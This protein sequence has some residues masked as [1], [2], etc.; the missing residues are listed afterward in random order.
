LAKPTIGVTPFGGRPTK[1]QAM[2]DQL[3]GFFTRIR[4]EYRSMSDLEKLLFNEVRHSREQQKL[5][6][7]GNTV[8]KEER[9]ING[10]LLAQ[11]ILAAGV[12]Q[13]K[14]LQ[15]K[16][17]RIVGDLDLRNSDVRIIVRLAKC[18]I[19][20]G[21]DISNSTT[22]TVDLA[23]SHL[24]C[25]R[26]TAATIVGGLR[27]A[28]GFLAR[29]GVYIPSATVIGNL[30]CSA[31]RLRQLAPDTGWTADKVLFEEGG[32]SFFAPQLT[33][34]G[35]IRFTNPDIV[36]QFRLAEPFDRKEDNHDFYGAI[37]LMNCHVQGMIDFSGSSIKSSK[38][39]AIRADGAKIGG[40]VFCRRGFVAIGQFRMSHAEVGADL[41]FTGGEF[42]GPTEEACAHVP[43]EQDHK[44]TAINLD[45]LEI[46]GS[47]I[48]NGIQNN[49]TGVIHYFASRSEVRL[50]GS[51]IGG[52]FRSNFA[53]YHCASFFL[54]GSALSMSESVIEGV[55]GFYKD[56]K[57]YSNIHMPY[58]TIKRKI[59][60][61]G[62]V[63]ADHMRKPK[64]SRYQENLFAIFAYSLTVE[65]DFLLGQ[66]EESDRNQDNPPP[67]YFP[68]IDV[69]A[70]LIKGNMRIRHAKY[71]HPK[72]EKSNSLKMQ[73]TVV[74]GFVTIDPESEFYGTLMMA[75]MSIGLF[76]SMIGIRWCRKDHS[77]DDYTCLDLSRTS[78]A[79]DFT[80]LSSDKD[81]GPTNV[82]E[83]YKPTGV[84]NFNGLRVGR[85]RDD[86]RLWLND[87]GTENEDV[88][89]RL[90][91]FTY[92]RFHPKSIS[93]DRL[94]WFGSEGNDRFSW[95]PYEQA[96][97]VYKAM[98]QEWRARTVAEQKQ[99]SMTNRLGKQ[100]YEE[101]RGSRLSNPK[102][103]LRRVFVLTEY[104]A[105][106]I[107]GVTVGYGYRPYTAM[108]WFGIFWIFGALFFWSLST[109]NM[110]FPKQASTFVTGNSSS[111][112][113]RSFDM[114][115]SGCR[116]AYY[117]EFEPFSYSLDLMTPFLPFEQ[118]EY[119]EI[120][121][122][123]IDDENSGE[124]DPEMHRIEQ[125]EQ[126]RD[127]MDMNPGTTEP[128]QSLP[129]IQGQ[130]DGMNPT[131]P[132][133]VSVGAVS[134][135]DGEAQKP[136]C[137]NFNDRKII[138]IFGLPID[139]DF[140]VR[141]ARFYQ[142]F[143][144]IVGHVLLILFAISPTRLLRN[145]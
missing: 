9:Y 14:E 114:Q 95:Q 57:F 136:E 108:I 21:V 75:S 102:V 18:R 140:V 98:G 33:V 50:L 79:G 8:S 77:T 94:V 139:S 64:D 96:Y 36:E 42:E 6:I 41:D 86:Q 1:V 104:A 107:M 58:C 53:H 85:L 35:S 121:G 65:G 49:E 87:K 11:L 88:V 124:I 67:E 133:T 10:G 2:H 5:S 129:Q 26:G 122:P 44:R 128:E 126:D 73:G 55:L 31:A 52:D 99:K 7:D 83:E 69:S 74:H 37:Y 97:S 71:G 92:D 40:G 138:S 38:I 112:N 27:L 17:A 145:D 93:F 34:K 125:E 60:I 61:E 66:T 144:I 39:Y 100:A 24:Q 115:I 131:G 134:G 47:L 118:N 16:K 19:E 20:G 32:P 45:G 23:G 110:F 143:H 54:D 28:D 59:V 113:T 89:F 46:D 70:S 105:R 22:R 63:A 48:F 111:S 29:K 80:W 116:P 81:K 68:R 120:R 106:V 51:R 76:L 103:V 4:R 78:I 30:D 3:Q 101:F 137:N 84:V 13:A 127:R 82:V 117:P 12:V 91:G 135:Q 109:Q 43:P 141:A 15:I 72:M 56:T 130:N 119:W 90:D 62:S 25:F 142:Y 132:S 123:R